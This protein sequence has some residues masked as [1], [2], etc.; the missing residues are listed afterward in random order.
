MQLQELT[1]LYDNKGLTRM[2]WEGGVGGVG[3]VFGGIGMGG[4]GVWEERGACCEGE[5]GGVFWGGGDRD[6]C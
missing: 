3:G 1:Q 4:L 6:G 2:V 5:R